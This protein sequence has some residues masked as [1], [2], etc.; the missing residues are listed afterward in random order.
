MPKISLMC[1][2]YLEDQF[3][4]PTSFAWYYGSDYDSLSILDT[5]S[6]NISPSL[7]NDY[8]N[9]TLSIIASSD[10]L[11]RCNLTYGNHH[12]LTDYFVVVVG[13]KYDTILIFVTPH[14]DH[15]FACFSSGNVFI[16]SCPDSNYRRTCSTREYLRSPVSSSILFDTRLGYRNGG[17]CGIEQDIR[18]LK[19]QKLEGVGTSNKKQVYCCN[20]YAAFPYCSN[21]S[22]FS[23]SNQGT[24]KFDFQIMLSNLSLSD[25]GIYILEVEMFALGSLDLITT[26]KIFEL[27]VYK[28]GMFSILIIIIEQHYLSCLLFCFFHFFPATV[29]IEL[30][31]HCQELNE[32]CQMFWSCDYCSNTM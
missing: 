20:G 9:I 7:E 11:Y 31:E 17:S 30:N 13:K 2:S 14:A 28:P 26:R 10:G 21:I 29:Y 15:V 6:S 4:S 24:H 16:K 19:L 23:V 25:A 32:H 3:S 8:K 18:S 22:R 5:N 12:F 27:T 1:A